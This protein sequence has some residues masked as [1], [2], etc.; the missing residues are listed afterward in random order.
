MKSFV[1]LVVI[2]LAMFPAISFGQSTAK[3]PSWPEMKKFH[4]YMASTFHPA[5]E[6]NFAPLKA[7][8]DSLL[9]SAKAWQLSNIPSNYKPE[10]TK[11][12]LAKLVAQCAV[13][14]EAV[15]GKADDSKLKTMI[16]DAHEIFHKIVGECKK[17]DH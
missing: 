9:I 4:S 15:D 3:S 1:R 7:K 11:E 17:A 6:D 5:E 10:E 13:I 16:T 12:T 8:A 14:K 2:V